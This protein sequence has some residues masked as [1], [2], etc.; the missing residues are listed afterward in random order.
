MRVDT[1]SMLRILAHEL[2]S[3]AGVAQGYIK[4]VLDGAL[5]NPADQRRALEQT[6]QAI[7]RMSA[8][9]REASEVAAWLECPAKSAFRTVS[10]RQLLDPFLER[11][12]TGL[13]VSLDGLDD[14]ALVST[15]D[16]AV[17]AKALTSLV[18]AIVRESPRTR[19]TL[20][21]S[22][23]VTGSQ[24][25]AHESND[26]IDLAVGPPHAIPEVF[27][28]PSASIAGQIPLERGG[29]GLSL[30][31]AVLV[32][33]AHGIAV[34]TINNQRAVLGVRFP[35]KTGQDS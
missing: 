31:M 13:D 23:K 24:P 7:E 29:L 12:D 21:A 4:M 35:V 34:W 28:G 14:S 5:P 8:I 26:Y 19:L 16:E 30:V 2:R 3:P 10:L 22:A 32:L 6:R 11:H 15:S 18:S 20:T 25:S 9:G 17:L 33:D 27:L 1:A